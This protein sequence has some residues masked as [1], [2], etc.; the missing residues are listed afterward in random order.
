MAKIKAIIFDFD[1]LMVNTEELREISFGEF[2]K[3]RGKNFNRSDYSWTMNG[4]NSE[5][6]TSFLMEKYGLSGDVSELSRE[7]R[8]I[9][10]E[11]FQSRLEL[12][13]GVSD[14]LEMVGKLGVKCAVASSRSKNDVVDGLTRLGVID[15]FDVVVNSDE[16][17]G[18]NLKPDPEIYLVTAQ[19]LGV[20]PL[21]CLVLEDSRH[22]AD[23]AIDAG[24]KVIY[25]PNVR[26]SD[27]MHEEADLVLKSMQELNRKVLHKLVY[28]DDSRKRKE[29]S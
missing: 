1:G 27:K 10:D 12:L 28:P 21:E 9:F 6:V 23:A 19:K 13:S 8:V 16:L 14:V 11:L 7:R 22:G 24:M 17:P 20:D 29:D 5:E 2:L 15:K 25:V 26:Y 18:G 3:R 4:K